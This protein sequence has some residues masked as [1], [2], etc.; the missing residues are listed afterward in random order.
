M[1]VSRE[2]MFTV[3][4]CFLTL[5]S[6]DGKGDSQKQNSNQSLR[7]LMEKRK[8][9]IAPK[10]LSFKNGKSEVEKKVL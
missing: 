4:K 3:R 1:E 6:R 7:A 5:S 9:K 2:E 8:R 10:K